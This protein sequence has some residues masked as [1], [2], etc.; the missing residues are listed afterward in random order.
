MKS[1]YD[2]TQ[3]Q[4]PKVVLLES[5]AIFDDVSIAVPFARIVQTILPITEYHS[6]WKSLKIEDFYKKPEYTSKDYLKGFHLRKDIV[7][8]DSSNYMIPTESKHELNEKT[9]L[10]LKIINKYCEHLG[11]KF[12]IFSVPSTTTWNYEKHNVLEEFTKNENIS[13]IDFNVLV[14]D[15]G[16]DWNADTLDAGEHM[17]YYGSIK[18]TNYFEKYLEE[19]NLLESHKNDSKYKSWD[20]DLKKYKEEI[21]K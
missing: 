3:K 12:I 20:Y 8:A 2:A 14:D 13:F 17:N 5:N 9:K 4:K 19:N 1:L 6:R 11:A 21:E 10:Y 16:I 15:I 18:L 7:P